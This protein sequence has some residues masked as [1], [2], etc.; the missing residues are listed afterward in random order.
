MS[1]IVVFLRPL[2]LRL[3]LRSSSESGTLIRSRQLVI[4]GGG[5]ER[6][7]IG[8]FRKA[9]QLAARPAERF[10]PDGCNSPEGEW[11]PGKRQARLDVEAATG[12]SNEAAGTGANREKR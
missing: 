9:G 11:R 4:E 10:D 8:R 7:G 5:G 2:G 6:T 3:S 1:V 12:F